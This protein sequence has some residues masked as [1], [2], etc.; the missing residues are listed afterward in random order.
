MFV[1]NVLLSNKVSLN[2]VR[3]FWEQF[4]SKRNEARSAEARF[5]Q[6][7]NATERRENQKTLNVIVF[8]IVLL[9]RVVIQV[10]HGF[11][12]LV[13]SLCQCGVPFF[14]RHKSNLNGNCREKQCVSQSSCLRYENIL[15]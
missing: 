7:N 9:T 10:G 15:Q 12:D 1:N 6:Q 4:W 5:S 13:Y 3:Y 8:H 14:C 11:I 2:C